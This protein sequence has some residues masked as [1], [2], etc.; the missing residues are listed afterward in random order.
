MGSIGAMKDGSSDRYFQKNNGK[1]VPEGIE[2]MVPQKG[3]IRDIVF[4]LVGG[5]RASM[6]YCGAKNLSDFS[7]KAVFER[8]TNAGMIESHPHDVSLTK[9]SLTIKTYLKINL[10]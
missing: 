4:Q 10:L 3:P 9:E 8:I 1:L 6:G 7:N 2:G 5:L